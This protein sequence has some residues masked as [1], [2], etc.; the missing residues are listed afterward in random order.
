MKITELD[1]VC[2]LD[3]YEGCDRDVTLLKEVSGKP[4]AVIGTK[5]FLSC[6]EIERLELPE[7]V[8]RIE[9]W[10]FAHMKNLQKI[11]LPAKDI[12]L[13]K[14]VF[15][16]CHSLKRVELSGTQNLYEGIPYFLASMLTLMVEV[17][18]SFQ[19]AG[20]LQG[21]WNFLKDYDKALSQYLDREDTYGFEPAFIGWFNVEDVDDQQQEFIRERRKCKIDLAF[22]RL[23]YSE[24]LERET[25]K[26]LSEYLLRTWELVKE[27]FTDKE[28]EYSRNVQYYRIWKKIG[29][30]SVLAPQALLDEMTEAEPE[31]RAFLVECE[32]NSGTAETFFAELEL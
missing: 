13:G 31:V 19:T 25:E 26:V 11:V 23:L 9:D 20:D 2:R 17:P 22:Q 6:R 18:V 5:A 28:R 16:G 7:T 21:Q 24:G 10:A 14:K 4:L 8:N 29:G 12:F 15:L 3:K 30:F 1:E 27:L 32:L